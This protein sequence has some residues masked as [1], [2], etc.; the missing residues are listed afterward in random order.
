MRDLFLSNSDL[1]LRRLGKER[2]ESSFGAVDHAGR[3]RGHSTR[4]AL[5][6][7]KGLHWR[8]FESVRA[9]AEVEAVALRL[10]FGLDV[11]EGL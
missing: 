10:R 9:K 4:G 1:A 7:P 2:A 8:I 5:Q 6:Q 3:G 11:G